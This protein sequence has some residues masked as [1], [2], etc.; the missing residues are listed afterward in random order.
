MAWIVTP[1]ISADQGIARAALAAQ[2]VAAL[3]KKKLSMISARGSDAYRT[4]SAR[5]LMGSG[6]ALVATAAPELVARQ[7]HYL[8]H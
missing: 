5:P 7:L 8:P 2:R 3:Q 1:L 4:P 6:R